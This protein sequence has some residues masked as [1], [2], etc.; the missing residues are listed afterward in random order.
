MFIGDLIHVRQIELSFQ[1]GNQI[2]IKASI[3]LDHPSSRTRSV[4]SWIIYLELLTISVA[5]QT[6]LYSQIA[7]QYTANQEIGVE[8]NV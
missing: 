2:N 8:G 3:S 1:G 4:D 7:C 6:K 5:P